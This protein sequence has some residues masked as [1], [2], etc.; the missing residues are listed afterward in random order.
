MTIAATSPS[1]GKL[2]RTVVETLRREIEA[3]RFAESQLL[4]GERALCEL[5]EVSRTTLR[6]LSG[7]SGSSGSGMSEAKTAARQAASGRRAHQMCSVDMCPCRI[8]FSRADCS[9]TSLRGRATSMR[10]L[11]MVIVCGYGC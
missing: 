5:L 10:R 1:G 9:E 7:H 8:D 3:G 11:S 2:Y 6:K 4:P